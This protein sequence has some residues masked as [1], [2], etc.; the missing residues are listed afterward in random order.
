MAKFKLID[1]FDVWKDEEDG[2]QVTICA[3][4]LKR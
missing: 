4:L 1:Y 2:W 3:P